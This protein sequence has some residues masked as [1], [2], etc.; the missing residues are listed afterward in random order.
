MPIILKDKK[1]YFSGKIKSELEIIKIVRK[2]KQEGMKVGLGVGGYDLLHPGHMIHLSSAKKYC[3][4]LVI[5]VTA[6]F[7]NSQRKGEGRPIYPDE[8]RVFSLSQLGCV[9]YVFISNYDT[10]IEVINSIKPNFYIKGPDY[11]N[12]ID[13]EINAERDAIKKVGGKIIYT[14]DEKFSTSEIIDYIKEKVK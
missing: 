13:N 8:L 4:I 14:E 7:F 3:D 11:K 9:D 12:K 2:L 5:G 1:K 10:A 6:E